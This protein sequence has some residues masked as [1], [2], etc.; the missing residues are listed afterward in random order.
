MRMLEP[1]EAHISRPSVT[2]A[3]QLDGP[4]KLAHTLVDLQ[5]ITLHCTI[6]TARRSLYSG[7]SLY[8]AMSTEDE[9]G[10]MLSVAVTISFSEVYS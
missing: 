6:L 7:W 1:T 3:F 4:S 5:M 9:T 8:S 10:T 2:V